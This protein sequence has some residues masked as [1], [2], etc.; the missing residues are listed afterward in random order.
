MS[1]K[2][3]ITLEGKPLSAQKVPIASEVQTYTYTVFH[4]EQFLMKVRD[5]AL[6]KVL[7]KQNPEKLTK[8]VQAK[9]RVKRDKLLEPGDFDQGIK[10]MLDAIG[11]GAV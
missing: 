2:K 3:Q 1:A 9:I 6:E 11:K 4:N 7:G 10:D 8:F 5:E